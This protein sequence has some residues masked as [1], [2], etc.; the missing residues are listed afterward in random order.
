M[1]NSNPESP[2][3]PVNVRWGEVSEVS[4]QETTAD[5]IHKF[6]RSIV[7]GDMEALINLLA[8]EGEWVIMA[9][10]ER[11]QG[12]GRIHALTSVSV[13]MRA[14]G[15]GLEP[16]PVSVFADADGTKICFEYLYRG[17]VAKDWPQSAHPPAPGTKFEIPVTLIGEIHRG[18]LVKI[19]EYFD[20]LTLAEAGAKNRL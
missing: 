9:T 13:V 12:S 2:P 7:Q 14:Q 15:A 3:E 10:G 16:E 20:W 17:L 19:R 6:M 8:P 1:M 4:P 5:F 11:F 18:K